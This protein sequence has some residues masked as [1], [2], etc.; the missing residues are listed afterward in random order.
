M[1]ILVAILAMMQASQQSEWPALVRRAEFDCLATAIAKMPA[2][3][4]IYV[5][6]SKCPT[7]RIQNSYP[8]VPTESDRSTPRRM[9]RLNRT[10][11]ACLRNNRRSLGKIAKPIGKALYL[12]D[13]AACRKP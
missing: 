13:L 5:D 11:S 8:W 2:D 3:R 6:I 1:S 7:A 4:T 12:V 10:Q 9:L